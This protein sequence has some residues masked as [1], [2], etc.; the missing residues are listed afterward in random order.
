MCAKM[1]KEIKKYAE[2]FVTGEGGGGLQSRG[3]SFAKKKKKK[4][5]E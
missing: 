3:F 5:S 2:P 4:K 1:A